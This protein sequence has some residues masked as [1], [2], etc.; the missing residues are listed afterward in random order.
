MW[1]SL[2]ISRLILRL[3]LAIVLLSF[4]IYGFFHPDYWLNGW[5]P[6]IFVSITSAIHLPKEAL[7]YALGVIELL[8]G[9]SLI[10]DMFIEAFAS[11]AAVIVLV[12]FCHRPDTAVQG[13]GL[14]GALLALAFWPHPTFR[15]R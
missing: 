11:V 8:I 13:I 2:N 5:I 4:G 6:H 3:S 1:Q 7:V 9:I 14:L 15:Y 12:L 10:S